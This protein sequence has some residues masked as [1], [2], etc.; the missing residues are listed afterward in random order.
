MKYVVL[1]TKHHEGFCNWDTK[2]TNYNSVNL[3]PKRDIVREYVEACRAEG[4]RVGF[5][6]SLMDW[7]H[8]DGAK[9]A[10]DEAARRR[11]VD[12]THG[13]IRELLTNYGK[14]DVL[15]YDVHWP[16]DA[17]GWESERMNKM[18]FELQPE[19][20]VNN[21][22]DLPGDFSTPEQRIVAE[23]GGRP[24]ES[25]MTLND[26]WGYQAADDNWKSSRTVIRNLITCSR[27]GGNYLLNIG[28]RG[29]DGSIPEESV[30]I[31]TE[32]GKW[33]QTGGD[34]IYNNADT[35]QPRSS[36]Y[37]SFTR[38]GNQLQMHVHFWPGTDVSISGLKNKVLSAKILKTGAKV[39]V[40]QDGF[41]THLTGLP[42]RAPD[43]PVT[44]IVLECDGVPAQD[45]DSVRHDKPRA[46]V[47][48]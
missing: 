6:Y 38:R 5:Y 13:L 25:C 46:G 48:I 29:T 7:H 12:Y 37:A 18:V 45:T 3:G 24:W 17:K 26:S 40:T 23:K 32:V 42:E 14:I 41:R 43:T 1:T 9:C 27:D 35:C 19:I 2:L 30:R 31:L 33:M 44:T 36:E 22:N 15:W 20:I 47:G 39:T 34:C 10:T 8:P 16:L 21:R 4:L 28:P 11:F